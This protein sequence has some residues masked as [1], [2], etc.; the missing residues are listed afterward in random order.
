MINTL[1]SHTHTYIMNSLYKVCKSIDLKIS[2]MLDRMDAL[3]TKVGALETKVDT[4][5]EMLQKN[6]YIS[7]VCPVPSAD[8]GVLTPPRAHKSTI[9]I[10]A[11]KKKK[12]K[13][14]NSS[15]P[16]VPD[17]VYEKS[18]SIKMDM[19][20]DK[21]LIT[22]D[23]YNKKMFIKKYKGQWAPEHKGWVVSNTQN[24]TELKKNLKQVVS[25]LESTKYTYNL[26]GASSDTIG[27]IDNT[28]LA[29]SIT[30]GYAFIDDS[31]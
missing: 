28:H 18:G 21:T 11:N 30:D 23:T 2:K 8:S 13:K 26:D 6:D 1:H 19:Y 7:D 12:S 15:T 4:L 5:G 24:I 17:P 20:A 22:G 25:T 14:K 27:R 3:D 16:T 29:S 10:K 31:D 9:T